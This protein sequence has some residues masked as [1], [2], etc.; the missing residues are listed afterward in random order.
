MELQEVNKI[1]AE[2]MGYH[3]IIITDYETPDCP[4]C[5]ICGPEVNILEHPFLEPHPC[6]IQTKMPDY[7][8]K[9]LNSLI[10]VWW[11]A[12]I[13]NYYEFEFSILGKN[14]YFDIRGERDHVLGELYEGKAKSLQEAAAIATAKAI[15]SLTEAQNS[16]SKPS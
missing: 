14:Y 3:K 4:Y 6:N 13:F 2:Y 8:T 12:K 9:D 16:P 10:P 15:Q 7:Y 5:E 11:K 1:I